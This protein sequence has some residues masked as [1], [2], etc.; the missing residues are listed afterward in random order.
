MSL[1]PPGRLSWFPLAMDLNLD[2]GAAALLQS[3]RAVP[4]P[5]VLPSTTNLAISAHLANLMPVQQQQPIY[6]QMQTTSSGGA[7]GQVSW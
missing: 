3:H 4:A 5:L 6:P 2:P 7:A 1:L